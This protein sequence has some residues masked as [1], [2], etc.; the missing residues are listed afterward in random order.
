MA[1]S[2]ILGEDS[3]RVVGGGGWNSNVTP[4]LVHS[5]TLT[6][7]VASWCECKFE[8]EFECECGGRAGARGGAWVKGREWGCGGGEE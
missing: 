3:A 2:K 6:T 8:C 5:L 1:S 7:A 4:S